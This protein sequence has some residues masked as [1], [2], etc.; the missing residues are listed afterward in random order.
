MRVTLKASDININDEPVLAQP[1]QDST[2]AT[3]VPGAVAVQPQPG[4]LAPEFAKLGKKQSLK[5]MFI[6]IGILVG[7]AALLAFLIYSET[8]AVV[9]DDI[10]MYFEVEAKF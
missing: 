1:Q 8:K 3:P 6:V 10:S 2:S 7:I 5:A 4:E 9:G